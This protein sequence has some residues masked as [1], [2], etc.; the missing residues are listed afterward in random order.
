MWGHPFCSASRIYSINLGPGVEYPS[1][2]L[3][4]MM[5]FLCLSNTLACCSSE[6]SR[7][8][9]QIFSKNASVQRQLISAS[10][11]VN[12]IGTSSVVLGRRVVLCLLEDFYAVGRVFSRENEFILSLKTEAGNVGKRIV[13]RISITDLTGRLKSCVKTRFP[14]VFGSVLKLLR[15]SG[16]DIDTILKN[17]VRDV[18]L[19]YFPAFRQHDESRNAYMTWTY[20]YGYWVISDVSDSNRRTEG[21]AAELHALILTEMER[22][23]LCHTTMYRDATFPW[24]KAVLLKVA[25]KNLTVDQKVQVLTFVSCIALYQCGRYVDFL[26][27]SRLERTLPLGQRMLIGL[28]VQCRFLLSGVN[29]LQLFRL[30]PSIPGKLD[31]KKEQTSRKESRPVDIHPPEEHEYAT[32][33]I[34]DDDNEN[35]M[36]QMGEEEVVPVQHYATSRGYS[37]W[38]PRELAIVME[39]SGNTSETLFKKFQ[40]YQK[41]CR[42]ENIPDRSWAAFK[43]K[44]LRVK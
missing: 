42:E 20:N 12:L 24:L 23:K 5:G 27:L 18:G 30:H 26:N 13:G 1:R 22:R 43:R 44:L 32:E 36:P 16:T 34:T 11:I 17:G 41:R 9:L 35:A 10:G 2:C 40:T 37:R 14:M 3:T 29:T 8:P 7:P 39:V 4:D 25:E 15:V 19:G 38:S 6:D 31:M 28:Q 21:E 33:R